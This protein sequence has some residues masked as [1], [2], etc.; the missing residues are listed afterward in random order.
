LFSPS[1]PFFS[2]LWLLLTPVT[3][4]CFRKQGCLTAW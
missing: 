2:V 3:S 1:R 4:A